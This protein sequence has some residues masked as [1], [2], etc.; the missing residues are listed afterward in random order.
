MLLSGTA[1]AQTH[2]LEAQRIKNIRGVVYIEHFIYNC[3]IT[4]R[5]SS[6]SKQIH[7]NETFHYEFIKDIN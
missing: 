4:F 5:R 1:D 6:Y 2:R 7:L 3:S